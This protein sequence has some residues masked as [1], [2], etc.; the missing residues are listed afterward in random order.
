M[1]SSAVTRLLMGRTKLLSFNQVGWLCRGSTVPCCQRW[2]T[3]KNSRPFSTSQ[4][5][6]FFEDR[7]TKSLTVWSSVRELKKSPVP[8]L[9]LGLAGLLPF[10]GA[11]LYM[12]SSGSFLAHIALAQGA[13]GACILSFLGGVRWGFTL[14]PENPVQPDWVNLGYSVMP[15]LIAWGGLLLPSPALTIGTVM[16]GLIMAGYV[17]MAMYGYPAWFKGMRFVLT[18]VATLSLWTTL[19][20]YALLPSE[21]EKAE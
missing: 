1:K 10:V 8:A 12:V 21:K 17:D 4:R 2:L 15:S 9:T 3:E 13:Y 5:L 11:P 19:T 18:L 20:C 7:E 14:A 6:L 16:G